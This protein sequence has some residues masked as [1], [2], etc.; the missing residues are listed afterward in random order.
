MHLISTYDFSHLLT[1][2]KH[3]GAGLSRRVVLEIIDDFVRKLSWGRVVWAS[4][5]TRPPPMPLK[6]AHSSGAAGRKLRR[7]FGQTDRHCCWRRELQHNETEGR[8]LRGF[9]SWGAPETR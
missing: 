2:V 5:Y 9:P 1:V 4:F 7:F 3:L 6:A 8:Q